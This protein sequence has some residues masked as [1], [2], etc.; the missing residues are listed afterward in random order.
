M[1]SD[2]QTTATPETRQTLIADE[3]ALLREWRQTASELSNVDRVMEDLREELQRFENRRK[4]IASK[5][6]SMRR[7]LEEQGV[8]LEAGSEEA[9]PLGARHLP[10]NVVGAS[11]PLS[12]PHVFSLDADADESPSSLNGAD[13]AGS[14]SSSME[15]WEQGLEA[16]NSIGSRDRAAKLRAHMLLA[17]TK[18]SPNKAVARGHLDAVELLQSAIATRCQ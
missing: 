6:A 3:S 17:A 10:L 9:D 4:M 14:S 15:D 5:E 7:R 12:A 2:G 18:Q 11:G 1:C 16:L 13:S 8:Q